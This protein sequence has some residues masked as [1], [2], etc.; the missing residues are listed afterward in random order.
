MDSVD[1]KPNIRICHTQCIFVVLYAPI[2]QSLVVVVAKIALGNL[3]VMMVLA[4]LVPVVLVLV[5]DVAVELYCPVNVLVVVVP[6][7]LLIGVLVQLMT[8]PVILTVTMVQE[9]LVLVV[10][11]L[12]EL[13]VVVSSFE[14]HL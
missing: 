13:V 14:A 3:I 7:L 12:K 1:W 10:L 2:R 6:G 9:L 11:V 5:S 8:A 4:L